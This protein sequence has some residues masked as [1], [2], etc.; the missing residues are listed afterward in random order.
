MPLEQYIGK[1]IRSQEISYIALHFGAAL[2]NIQKEAPPSHKI[3]LVCATGLG[4]SKML[5]SQ[6]KINIDIEITQI[7]SIRGINQIKHDEYDFIVSTINIPG[8][9]SNDYIKVNPILTNSDY[10]QIE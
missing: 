1:P 8:L 2:K 3:V 10:K 9:D 6:I 7:T 4:T 5:V